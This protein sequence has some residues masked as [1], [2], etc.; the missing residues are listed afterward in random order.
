MT[1]MR[2]ACR[3]V[4]RRCA[5]TSVVRPARAPRAPLHQA[6]ALRVE[7]AGRLVEQQDRPVGEQRARDRK[8]LALA[9][10]Q[11][12]AALAERGVEALRQALD[13]LERAGPLARG[14]HLVASVAAAGRSARSRARSRRRSPD[15]AAPARPGR[16]L[17]RV[18]VAQV[19][20]VDAHRARLRVVEAQQQRE[21]VD[22]PAPEGPT[23]A[24]RSP[25]C[26]REREPVQRRVSGR[27]G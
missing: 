7:R 18:H 14:E 20:A 11:L 19:D 6:L 12:D 24:T 25:G 16:A 3:T 13:E 2:S 17:A 10:G 26:T 9:A 5:M 27:A 22:L 21:H 23:S 4:A 1:M 8:A 15:P